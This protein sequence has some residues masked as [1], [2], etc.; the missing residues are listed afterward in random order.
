[1]QESPWPEEESE[2][3]VFEDVANQPE[4]LPCL[5]QKGE[6]SK[7]NLRP[8]LCPQ[9]SYDG[10]L[11]KVGDCCKDA[12]EVILVAGPPQVEY[13]KG[14]ASQVKSTKDGSHQKKG[15]INITTGETSPAI[16]PIHFIG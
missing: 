10:W 12:E 11:C 15:K 8:C 16:A 6:Q 9:S 7:E 5:S 1:M 3:E 4:S 2:E 14:N 13:G